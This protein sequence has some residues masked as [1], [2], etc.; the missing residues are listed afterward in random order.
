MRKWYED[1]LEV[2]MEEEG[3]AFEGWDEGEGEENEESEPDDF[4]CWLQKQRDIEWG[5]GC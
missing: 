2:A 4:D 5:K 3:E 1:A